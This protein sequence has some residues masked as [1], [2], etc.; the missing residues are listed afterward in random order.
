[1]WSDYEECGRYF[2][3]EK[4]EQIDGKEKKR[5]KFEVNTYH[6]IIINIVNHTEFMNCLN[7]KIN[8]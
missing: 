3:E 5:M 4:D 6:K 7:D 8:K 1:V 2:E